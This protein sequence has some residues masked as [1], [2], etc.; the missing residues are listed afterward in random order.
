MG[1]IQRQVERRAEK[2][3]LRSDLQDAVPVDRATADDLGY[4]AE[5][6]EP[7]LAIPD[8]SDEG[9]AERNQH[10]RRSRSADRLPFDAVLAGKRKDARIVEGEEMRIT[11]VTPV[12]VD[13]QSPTVRV[14]IPATMSPGDVRL[15]R[16]PSGKLVALVTQD[17]M[18]QCDF[19]G[20]HKKIQ[21]P[22]R[23]EGA[24]GIRELR[25]GG[26]FQEQRH[27][28]GDAQRPK[29]FTEL[30]VGARDV[31]R[32]FLIPLGKD[33]DH[34]LWCSLVAEPV[35]GLIGQSGDSFAVGSAQ[36]APP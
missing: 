4:V 31:H 7:G 5:I 17:A 21:V 24:I 30:G 19:I 13:G 32:G 8:L 14:E 3:A 23:A 15:G 9:D 25:Q 27:H 34:F 6:P 1:G 29:Q 12:H 33:P 2:A 16:R 36:Q 22:E 18:D 35:D 20:R 11:S 10:V 28:P 26:T